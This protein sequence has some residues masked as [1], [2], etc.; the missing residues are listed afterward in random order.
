GNESVHAMRF[1]VEQRVRVDE[2]NAER[3]LVEVKILL[4]LSAMSEAHLAMIGGAD[5]QSIVAQTQSFER[6]E[7][8]DKVSI[9]QLHQIAVEVEV[10][11]LHASG[12]ELSEPKIGEVQE[13][14]LNVRFG[15]QILIDRL[16]DTNV[17]Q[18]P[19]VI[20]TVVLVARRI[21]EHVMRID[22]GDDKEEG[23]LFGSLLDQICERT[24]VTILPATVL[25][26][27]PAVIVRCAAARLVG[28]LVGACIRRVPAPKAVGVQIRG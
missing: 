14:L 21:E 2:R 9:L 20:V 6:V 13:L 18:E 4:S 10:M 26:H 23:L 5:D 22:Q 15:G 7:D 3:L 11:A 27:E 1:P 17:P 12:R 24:F 16:G 19:P 28:V 25:V 8:A